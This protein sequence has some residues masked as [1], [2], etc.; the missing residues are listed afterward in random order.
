MIGIASLRDEIVDEI[1]HHLMPH[2]ADD[3]FKLLRFHDLAALAEDHLALIVHHIVEF[4]KLL[5]DIKVAAFDLGLRPL[6]RFVDPRM[7]DGLA[8]LHAELGQN[9]IQTLRPENAHQ[10]VFKGKVER[11]TTRIALTAGPAAQ[12]I[13]DTPALVPLGAKDEKATGRLDRFLIA[14]VR[15]FDA[16]ADRGVIAFGI[17]SDGFHDLE[18]DVAAQFDVGPAAGHIGRDRHSAQ[19]AGIGDDLCLLFVL[20]GVKDVVNNAL[21]LQKLAQKL[22]LLDRGGAD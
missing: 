20:T 3:L 19:L 11:R 10:V 15:L 14:L 16:G 7:N 5:A 8:F 13:V 1:I 6:E 12:L 2:V 22:R 4:Q 9:A 18:F 21:F 17:G